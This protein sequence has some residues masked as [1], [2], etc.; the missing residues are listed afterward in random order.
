MALMGL[1]GCASVPPGVES[2]QNLSITYWDFR[3]GIQLTLV[4]ENNPE[5][6]DLYTKARP[7]ASTKV[8]SEEVLDYLVS[9]AADHSFFEHA[10]DIAT[11]NEQIRRNAY[12]MITINADGRDYSFVFEHGLDQRVRGSAQDF[13]DITTE[14]RTMYNRIG[15]LQF[16]GPD[17]ADSRY[18]DREKKRLLEENQK[19]MEDKDGNR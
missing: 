7:S 2:A 6:R 8:A 17:K 13:T 11:P 15:S 14:L 9:F 1:P 18:F 4:N 3:T 5:Y 10:Q 19:T 16:I 12:G